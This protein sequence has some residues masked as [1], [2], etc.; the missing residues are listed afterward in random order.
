MP[1]M[2]KWECM[3]KILG[4]EGADK[5]M[6]GTLYVALFLEVLLF[7]SEMWLV[8]PWME[9]TLEGFHQRAVRRIAVMGLERQLIMTWVYPPIGEALSNMGLED[10]G[11]YINRHQNTGAE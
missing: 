4:R 3:V 5:R 7:R 1:E 6:A 9:K 11:V 8:T 10:I 2:E